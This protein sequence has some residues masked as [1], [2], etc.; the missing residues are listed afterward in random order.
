MR[1]GATFAGL[2][3][4]TMLFETFLQ[5]LRIG[6]RVLVKEK[7]FCFLAVMVLAIGICAVATQYAVVNGV[8]LRG[9]TF[10]AAER[11]VGVQ[12]VDPNACR[13]AMFPTTFSARS[14]CPRSWGATS[15]PRTTVLA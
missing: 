8:L 3:I 4:T 2:T 12:L 1:I 7:S 13:E 5:D 6:L 11:L 14:V 15:R 10:P 9:F